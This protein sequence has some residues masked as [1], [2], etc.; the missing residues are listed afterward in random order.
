MSDGMHLSVYH[1]KVKK[2]L[3]DE[4]PWI[5]SV[6]H[7]P[8]TK[9]PLLTPSLFFSVMDWERSEHQPMNGQLSVTLNCE[10]LAI[11]GVCEPQYQ[12]DVRN[13]AMAIGLKVDGSCFG[14]PIEPATFISA[15]PDAFDP[16]L[17]AY[18]AWSIR[19]NQIINV[20]NDFFAPEGETPSGVNV[21]YSP[22]IGA[23]NEDK[24]E[25]L[26]P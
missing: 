19:F 23:D 18:A 8:E 16:D 17:D 14:M 3:T 22:D 6:E 15:E 20:G 24:Y 26:I 1:E 12:L 5:K 9:T 2:W 25:S 11:L 13:A 4:L 21:G 10:I 7:Y